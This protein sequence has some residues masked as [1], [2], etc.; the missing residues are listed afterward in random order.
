[1]VGVGFYAVM[2]V[3]MYVSNLCA[4]FTRVEKYLCL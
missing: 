1:M 2:C 4:E 3:S